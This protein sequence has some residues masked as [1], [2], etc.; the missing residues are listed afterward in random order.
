MS[1]PNEPR[2]SQVQAY[3]TSRSAVCGSVHSS[4]ADGKK[5]NFTIGEET[6][7]AVAARQIGS[8]VSIAFE[9]RLACVE[10]EYPLT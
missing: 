6:R 3:A 8:S 9:H 10:Q 4:L 2:R 5:E 7:A 1:S